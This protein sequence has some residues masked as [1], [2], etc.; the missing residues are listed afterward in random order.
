MEALKSVNPVLP[1]FIFDKHILDKL[2]DKDDARL[3]F[4]HR[5]VNKLHSIFKNHGS[6]IRLFHDFPEH[7]FKALLKDFNVKQV[8]TN[9]DYE[10]YAR[11][12]DHK[13]EELLKENDVQFHLIKDQ[14]IFEPS[15]ILKDDGSPYKVFT[16]F[17]NRWREKIQ[18]RDHAPVD[19]E[20][21]IEN[22]VRIEHEPPFTL[23]QLGFEETSVEIPEANFDD[24]LIKQYENKRNFPGIKGTSRLGI[25]LRHGTISVRQAVAEGIGTSETWLNELIWREFYMM[26]LYHWPKVVDQSFKAEYDQIEWQNDES[27]FVAW[28]DG[29]TGYP[30]VD[31]GMRELNETGFM[32]NRVR[33]ITSSF[34]TK[35]LLVDWR[36]GEHYFARKLLDFELASNNGGWQWAA[37]TGTDAQPY[38][39]IFNPYSQTDKF[40]EDHTY[41]KRWIPELETNK[42]PEPIVDYKFA[43][44]RA[45]D[46]YKKALG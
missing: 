41:I 21:Y 28:C 17:K 24:R 5:E 44:Q 12:R 1:I 19:S 11:E 16:P 35:M 25:H 13:I 3:T 8:F 45:I 22:L 39:R 42:Y 33:M 2:E 14:M 46:T 32:H 29:N 26:I 31:A 30:I 37:G 6:G 38:F 34:L 9:R 18:T 4:I 36:W 40:D 23:K 43:R 7:A 27:D 15:E 10:P 20:K